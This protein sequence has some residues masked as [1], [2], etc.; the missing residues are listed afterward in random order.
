M[1]AQE[2][3]SKL[4]ETETKLEKCIENLTCKDIKI[5]ELGEGN[6]EIFIFILL[7]LLRL[8]GKEIRFE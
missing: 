7:S 1:Y 3:E 4:N 2:L 5:L 8:N 6:Y